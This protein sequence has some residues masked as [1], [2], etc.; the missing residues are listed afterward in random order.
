MMA[1]TRRVG[2]H[3]PH[4]YFLGSKVSPDDS[5]GLPKTAESGMWPIE[6][7]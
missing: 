7:Y 3:V 6:K 2:A 5:P 1:A 4:I